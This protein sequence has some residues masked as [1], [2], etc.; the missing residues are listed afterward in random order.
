MGCENRKYHCGDKTPAACTQYDSILPD[1]V[2]LP[3]DGCVSVEQA[4]DILFK[5]VTRLREATDITDY[6]GT[7]V[8][9]QGDK[10]IANLVKAME[11]KIC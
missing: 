8:S 6:D 11:A 9:I 3:K 1:W 7:C 10:T 5:E 4:L 2:E